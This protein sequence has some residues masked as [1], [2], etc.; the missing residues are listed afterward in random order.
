MPG[1]PRGP[2]RLERVMTL[3][4][5]VDSAH[6]WSKATARPPGSSGFNSSLPPRFEA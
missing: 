5:E 2:Y 3:I 1:E 6:Q 4:D